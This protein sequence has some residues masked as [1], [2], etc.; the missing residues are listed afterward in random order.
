MLFHAFRTCIVDEIHP[1]LRWSTKNSLFLTVLWK[2]LHILFSKRYIKVFRS[3][4]PQLPF[5]DFLRDFSFLLS[6]GFRRI[7]RNS[8]WRSSLAGFVPDLILHCISIWLQMQW[9]KIAQ[10]SVQG[11]HNACVGV[12]KIW[13]N[14][15]AYTINYSFY[16]EIVQCVYMHGSMLQIGCFAIGSN[17]IY[18]KFDGVTS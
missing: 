5:F 3:I 18:W 11:N 16:F 6:L 8:C 2:K 4:F 17:E 7:S 12:S 1:T 14:F 9:N 10:R 13:K 15:H